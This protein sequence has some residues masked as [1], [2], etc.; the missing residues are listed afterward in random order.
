VA[1]FRQNRWHL[2][3][4]HSPKQVAHWGKVKNQTPDQLEQP[5]NH[6]S[7]RRD[8]RSRYRL[9]ETRQNYINNI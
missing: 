1:H 4:K 5:K 7:A 3:A 6:R 8:Q 2:V 9:A